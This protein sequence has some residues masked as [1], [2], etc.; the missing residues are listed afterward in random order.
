[1]A[2]IWKKNGKTI[3]TIAVSQKLSKTH[4]RIINRKH[5]RNSVQ[6]YMGLYFKTCLGWF[7][8]AETPRITTF[9]R[10]TLSMKGLFET[11]KRNDT[12]HKWSSITTCV[13]LCWMPHFIYCYAECHYPECHGALLGFTATLSIML[14]PLFFLLCWVP[15]GRGL[16]DPG[17]LI[18][19]SNPSF[20]IYI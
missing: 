4:K 20:H 11:L 8:G 12:K 1:M 14:S 6:K 10:T 18:I 13:L 5:Y 2:H 3:L 19:F 16:S 9:S 17:F 7:L 15:C